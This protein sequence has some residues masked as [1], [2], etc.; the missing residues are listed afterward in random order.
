MKK[1]FGIRLLCLCLACA[2]LCGC[3]AIGISVDDQLRPPKNNGEQ[4]ALQN[5][6]ES[7]IFENSAKGQQ[8]D[9][10][11][12]YPVDG[13]YRSS[14]ILLDQVKANAIIKPQSEAL[15]RKM[16]VSLSDYGIAFYR[17][18][19][20]GAKTH[21]NLLKKV[22]GTW[23]SVADVSGYS[24]EIA[25]VEFGDVDGNGFPEL[26]VGWN[27]Y[28]SNDKRLTVYDLENDLKILLANETCTAFVVND[29][30]LDTADD[31]L[32]INL[33][34]TGESSFGRLISQINDSFYEL[35]S[36]KLDGNIQRI[37]QLVTAQIE[38]NVVGVFV[39]AYKDPNT[40]I[41][42]LIYWKNNKLYAPFYNLYTGLTAFTA[43]EVPIFSGDIDLD[44][45][46]EWPQC[47]RLP[48]YEESDAETAM[49]KT[50][51][52]SFDSAQGKAVYE[53]D[54]I[55]N[56]EDGYVL[57][58]TA[59]WPQ[60]VTASYD[61]ALRILSFFETTESQ[62]AFLKIQTN[63]SGKVTDLEDGFVYFDATDS[64]HYAMWQNKE[65]TT[66]S[67]SMTEVQYLFSVL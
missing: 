5:A 12:K 48:G 3:Q 13:R 4:E 61:P 36:V 7:F 44:G 6:L 18:D 40:T 65:D 35:A 67:L 66:F 57:K 33:S 55:V 38:P 39:D 21:I 17:M 15:E 1:Q 37:D 49:W 9:Y 51:W 62:T 8:L 24:E 2:L 50:T 16:S 23:Q 58:F 54:S 41:T 46:V 26:I 27:M 52:Y 11:L 20:N 63:T 10:A 47:V 56:V 31:L 43:R 45:V 28:N 60:T 22:N 53:F 30:T 29:L 34:F 59:D 19:I 42:E 14:F 64:L 25:Q 32:L